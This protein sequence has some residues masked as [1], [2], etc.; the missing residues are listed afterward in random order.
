MQAAIPTCRA[1]SHNPVVRVVLIFVSVLFLA[2]FLDR[3]RR[4]G[5]RLRVLARARR[6]P[7]GAARA[8]HVGRDS[9]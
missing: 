1:R 3:A 6:L 8:R 5:A 2:T 9:A 4:V 7:R